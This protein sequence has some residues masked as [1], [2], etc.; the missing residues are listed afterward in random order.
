MW[1]LC[2]HFKGGVQELG[3]AGG[4][5]LC[6]RTQQRI[7]ES[8]VFEKSAL[9]SAFSPTSPRA[10]GT[11]SLPPLQLLTRVLRRQ[12]KTA[13]TARFVFSCLETSC[14]PRG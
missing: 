3:Q 6:P 2:I 8:S 9:L 13:D 5:P 12:Q 1:N 7:P 4:S 14:Q 11:A 10:R